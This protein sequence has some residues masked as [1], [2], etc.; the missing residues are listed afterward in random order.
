MFLMT[1]FSLT[2][3]SDE[4]LTDAGNLTVSSSTVIFASA[5]AA[6]VLKFGRP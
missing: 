3:L 4:T 6:A 2:L 1:S 5:V